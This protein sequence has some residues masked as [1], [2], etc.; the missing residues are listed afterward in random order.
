MKKLKNKEGKKILILQLL[1]TLIILICAFLVLKEHETKSKDIINQ[2][3]AEMISCIKEEYPN[4]K[5]EELIQVLNQTKDQK[6]GKEV[7][8]NYGL[9]GHMAIKRFENYERTRTI[10]IL[11]LLLGGS[12]LF[13]L[14]F[15]FYLKCRQRKIEE[16]IEYVKKIER[17]E[18]LL[19]VEEHS[20]DELNQL[21]SELYKIM[22]MLKEQAGNSKEQSK[23]LSIAVSDISHQLKTPLTSILI[24]LDN[25]SESENM[26]ESTKRRFLNE[27]SSQ[28]K[29][30]NW[31][32]I[33]LLKLSKLDAGAVEF[34][35]EEI[36]VKTLLNDILSN[37]EIL[38]EL[39]QVQID[40]F[41]SEQVKILGDYHW[42]K[43]AIQNIVKNAIEHTP[44]GKRIQIKVEE[45]VAYT[46][47]NVI[48]EGVGISWEDQK[49]IFDRFYKA[50]NSS[51]ESFGIGLAMAK[52]IVEKQ[53]GYVS[54]QS[55]EGKGTTLSIQYIK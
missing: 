16:L 54:V 3:V 34:K 28:I 9:E 45:N 55:E 26:E 36:N 46:K 49:H 35:K 50:K 2:T 6:Q 48:D 17:K 27:I 53:N 41:C 32:V 37:L 44:E 31:L 47:I 22:V 8:R 38:A 25:L 15:Y 14:L 11:L 42:N 29:G 1:V 7:L 43:E 20:E 5:E 24:L 18:Y 33:S 39:K 4:V 30:M 21:K 13:V 10:Q 40:L 23:S 19:D 52:S 12:F 51:E